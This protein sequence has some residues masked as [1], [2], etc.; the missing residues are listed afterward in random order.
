MNLATEGGKEVALKA[1]T[2]RRFN[3][4]E[5][6]DN[7]ALPAGAPMYYYCHS[8]GHL[9]AAL[10]ESHLERPPQLCDECQAMKDLGWLE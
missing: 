2:D 3:K 5:K 1:L 8:C 10:P 4:P 9:A 6:I 7:S